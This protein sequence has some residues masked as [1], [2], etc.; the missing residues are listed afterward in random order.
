MQC[1]QPAKREL[2][3]AATAR[4][5]CA[6]PLP[7]SLPDAVPAQR[8]AGA[9]GIRCKLNW[10]SEGGNIRGSTDCLIAAFASRLAPRTFLLFLNRFTTALHFF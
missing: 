4:F 7:A 10:Y 9:Q 5:V 6:L 1:L 8:S 3:G 2:I